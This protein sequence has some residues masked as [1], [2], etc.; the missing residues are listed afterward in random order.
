MLVCLLGFVFVCWLV[1]E[2]DRRQV[3]YHDLH[4]PSFQCTME[5]RG[6]TSPSHNSHKQMRFTTNEFHHSRYCQVAPH[7]NKAQAAR[8]FTYASWA[9]FCLF[10]CVFVCLFVCLCCLLACLF[11][12]LLAC[13][14]VCLFTCYRTHRGPAFVC[15]FVC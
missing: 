4:W 3:S 5:L 14:F 10:V 11:L 6:C 7:Y 1:A 12:C 9:S 15:F 2:T 8:L 13:L